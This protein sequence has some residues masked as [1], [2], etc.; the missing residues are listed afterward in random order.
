MGDRAGASA[1][2]KAWE[3][4][5]GGEGSSSD[6]L[7]TRFVESLSIDRSRRGSSRV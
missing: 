2:A 5:K 4:A 7:A 1:P 6:P 3:A